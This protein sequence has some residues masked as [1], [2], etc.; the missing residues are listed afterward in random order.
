MNIRTQLK[1]MI[2]FLLKASAKGYFGSKFSI[3]LNVLAIPGG[4][5]VMPKLGM[6]VQIVLVHVQPNMKFLISMLYI[7][8]TKTC[9]TCST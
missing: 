2:N 5:E 3:Y 6:G 8:S 7:E 1:S 9:F 4:G